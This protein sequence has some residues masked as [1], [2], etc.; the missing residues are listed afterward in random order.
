MKTPAD[1]LWRINNEYRKRL[2][3]A[4]TYLNIL[5]QL[6]LTQHPDEYILAALQQALAQVEQ[7]I[8]E[9][10]HW[11]Y[12]YY[13]DSADSQRMV[14]NHGAINQALTQFARMRTRHEHELQL[15]HLRLY[16]LQRPDPAIT[17]VPVGDLWQ[18]SQFALQ[19][20]SGFDQYLQSISQV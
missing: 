9:H 1:V 2:E 15:I 11:R 12:N 7:M 19:D 13:Y 4:R 8:G 20:L 14:Q 10:R 6:V 17:S 3:Q 18:L 16:H 5:E